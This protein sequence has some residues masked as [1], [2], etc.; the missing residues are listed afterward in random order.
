MESIQGREDSSVEKTSR[1]ETERGGATVSPWQMEM[2]GAGGGR[3]L[4]LEHV[5][6]FFSVEFILTVVRQKSPSGLFALI[7]G[8]TH[9]D[10]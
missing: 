6:G 5:S 10:Y 9:C 8:R 2:V 1:W 7:N 4:G 3:G